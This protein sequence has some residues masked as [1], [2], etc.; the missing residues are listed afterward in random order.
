[1]QFRKLKQ[2]NVT[3]NCIC[4]AFSGRFF[5]RNSPLSSQKGVSIL[6]T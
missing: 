3:L 4:F 5:Y 1:M 6:F 2:R